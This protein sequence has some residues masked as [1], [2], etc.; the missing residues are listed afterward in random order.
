MRAAQTFVCT[1]CKV[2]YG[3][4]CWECHVMIDASVKIFL[5]RRMLHHC[6]TELNTKQLTCVVEL[7]LQCLEL[8]R[9]LG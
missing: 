8:L 5:I 6:V 3:M 4:G 1:M 2:C 7:L 9:Y